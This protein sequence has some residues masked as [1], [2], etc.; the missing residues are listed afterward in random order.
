[1]GGAVINPLRI[2]ETGPGKIDCVRPV[3]PLKRGVGEDPLGHWLINCVLMALK[4]L[5]EWSA[6]LCS[7]RMPKNAPVLCGSATLNLRL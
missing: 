5:V 7:P 2:Q 1:M 6:G 3:L 4:S